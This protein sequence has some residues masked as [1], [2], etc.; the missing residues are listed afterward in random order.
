MDYIKF[1]LNTGDYNALRSEVTNINCE[2]MM[3]MTM[4]AAWQYFFPKFDVAIKRSVPLT[5]PKPKFKN[6]Y[7][8]KDAI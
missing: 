8:N 1:N 3:N 6:I 2:D 4:D 7:T 5:S